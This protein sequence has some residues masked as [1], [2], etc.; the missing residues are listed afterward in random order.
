MLSKNQ[1]LCTTRNSGRKS[2]VRMITYVRQRKWS[3]VSSLVHLKSSE[4]MVTCVR[5]LCPN[6]NFPSTLRV[7]KRDVSGPSFRKHINSRHSYQT[8]KAYS[9]QTHHALHQT[10][11]QTAKMSEA[12]PRITA[13]Y[14]E[15]FSHQTVRILGGVRQLRGEQA[16]IDAGGQITLHLNRVCTHLLAFKRDGAFAND[17]CNHIG[18]APSAQQ[19]C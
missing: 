8:L 11:H 2:L 13:P 9:L 1:L 14:L 12:T 18:L 3:E 7:V 17:I 15:Q 6:V 10:P 4:Q 5:T 19:C 16:T